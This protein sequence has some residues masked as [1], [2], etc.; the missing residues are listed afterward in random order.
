MSSGTKSKRKHEVTFIDCLIPESSDTEDKSKARKTV[1][2]P[3]P[4]KEKA[5]EKK[6]LALVRNLLELLTG[7]EKLA[8][9]L[10]SVGEKDQVGF[11]RALML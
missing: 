11:A 7:L 9:D 6:Q 4:K 2:I 3:I 10:Q 8:H 5:R 1:K